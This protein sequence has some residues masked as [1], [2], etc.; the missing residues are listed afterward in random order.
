V[1]LIAVEIGLRLAGG[2]LDLGTA[3]V[4]LLLTPECYLPLRRVGASF[5]AAQSGLDASADLHELL[6]RPTLAVGTTPA[7]AAGAL[8][9]SNVTLRRGGRVILEGLDLQVT[10]ASITAVYGPSGVGKSTLIDACR[11]RLHER[12][13]SIT[14]GGIDV[15]ELDPATWADQ[16]TTIGQRLSPDAVPV[17]D[18]VR[19]ATGASDA[20]ILTALT[21]VGL[22][23]VAD[24][25]TDQLSGGQLRRVHV[26]R[27]LVAVRTGHAGY[28]L[29][30]EPTAHLDAASANAVWAA[31]DDLA[32]T[33]GAAVLVATHDNRCRSFAEHVID[34]AADDTSPADLAIPAPT[35]RGAD[36]TV[37]LG[38]ARVTPVVTHSAPPVVPPAASRSLR[39]DLR[40]VLALA[41]PVR[42]RLFGAAALGTAAEI[43]T[44][45]LAGAAAWLVIK[46]GEQPEIAALSIAILGVR[47]FGTGKGAFRYAERL[48]THDA[49]LRSLTEIRAAVV[50]RL[51]EIAPAG[52]PGWQ[53]GDLL[54]RMVADVDRLLDLFVRVLGP[55]VAV[56]ATATG[57]L[58]IT[59]MLDVPA[60][61][62]LL[63][64]L[65]IVGVVVPV[66][67]VR[68]ELGLGP[69]LAD[70][71]AVL[72]GQAL[73]VTERLDQLWANRTL[74][75]A[76][77]DIERVGLEIDELEKRRARLRAATG[78]VVAAA[79][80]LT[81][82]AILAA[83]A[84]VGTSAS[85]P[86][87]GVLVLWPL[88]ILELVGTLNEASASVPSLGGSAHRVLA[89]LDTPD[90]VSASS[91]K[92]A[93]ERRPTVSLRDVTAR[94]PHADVDALDATSFELA[95]GSHASVVGPS[96]SGKSTLAAV[97]VGF[98]SPRSGSYRLDGTDVGDLIG[99]DLRRRVT[100]IQQIPWIA[101]STV[102]ENLRLADPAASDDELRDVLRSVRLDEW[103]RHLPAGLDSQL[104]RGGSAMSGGEAQRLALARVLLAEHDVVV[105]DEPT[106]NLDATT[107][108]QVLDTVLDRCDDRTTVLLGHAG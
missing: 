36:V 20:S 85:G 73:G 78:A 71:R 58:V 34:L 13:G 25:R 31:L 5:H 30:D 2:S 38:D 66:F 9:V 4:V 97:L 67:T 65:T 46:A 74:E 18:E 51:A 19:A 12:S 80:L 37:T 50:T 62:V 54:Q 23:D 68:T 106:A 26:A 45:G 49:G 88:A 100:W 33:R 102:R 60:G 61:A 91:A 17:L 76:R 8:V 99:D 89:V 28:V 44:I 72:G 103:F 35:E 22:A 7:P 1:A 96:G 52:I 86:V 93:V 24:R 79:P 40:R 87:I 98:L 3:L 90:P 55:A 77:N 101:D 15:N 104:G 6:T 81:T 64:A 10:S 57:A 83:V 48:A 39:A 47:A 92:A 29:A 107:A 41:R 70:T 69:A 56:A 32:R 75:P 63:V 16:L 11:G 43:C 27:A 82:T 84:T 108:A 14:V 59:L 95:P 42:R 105:L 53:R 21:D 94:W